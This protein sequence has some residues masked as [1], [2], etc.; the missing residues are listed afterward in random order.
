M[1]L[2]DL[3]FLDIGHSIGLIGAVFGD[4]DTLYLMLFPDQMEERKIQRLDLDLDEWKRVL[5]QTDL[6]E[7]EITETATDGK[8]TKAIIRKSQRMIDSRVCWKVYERDG[9]RCRYC[10]KG[11]IPLTVDHLVLWEEN[12]PSTEANLVT[13]CRKDNK[14]RGRTPYAEWL[15]CSY[16]RKASRRLTPVQQEQNFNLIATL[17]GIERVKHK[18]TK[19]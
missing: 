12:G 10:G 4:T 3:N 19:R 2:D 1:K 8:V 5:R 15:Q 11:G 16:Y 6:M 9:Y 14:T 13:S 17:D 7:T 18:R